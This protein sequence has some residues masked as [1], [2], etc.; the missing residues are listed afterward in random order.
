M[1][2]L[3]LGMDNPKDA[4]FYPLLQ[5]FQ[6]LGHDLQS[7]RV[8]RRADLEADL[9]KTIEE[10]KPDMIFSIGVWFRF[11]DPLVW[12]VLKRY[13]VPHVYWAIED[14]TFF[15]AISLVRVKEY[16]FVLTIS[17]KCIENYAKLGVKAVH[18]P[19]TIDPDFHKTVTVNPAFQSD[20]IATVNAF[21][22]AGTAE[23]NFRAHSFNITIDPI[24]RTR[25]IYNIKLYGAH[26]DPQKHDV[27]QECL[28]GYYRD[29]LTT[30]QIYSGSKIVLG[31]QR[32]YDGHITFRTFESLAYGRLLISPYTPVQEEFFTHG[33]HLIYVRSAQET[34]SYVNYYLAH[35]EQRT[36]I[37]L[38]G[39]EEVLKNHN[40]KVRAQQALNALKAAGII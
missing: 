6:Q 7:F 12:D 33:K 10:Y 39:Q 16:H 14:S 24:I 11:F 31:V 20:I 36:K 25:K 18:I 5:G 3:H 23:T 37:A 30:Q 1:K 15:H 22:R 17:K 2:I 32:N 38:A 4:Y 13:S 21:N 29:I 34:K 27:P 9:V 40:C 8:P 19:H 35:P 28:G 26:W